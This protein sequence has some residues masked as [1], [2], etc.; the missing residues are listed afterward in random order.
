MSGRLK[1]VFDDTKEANRQAIVDALSGRTLPSMLDI[2]PH[3]GGFTERVAKAVGA[4]SIDGIELIP[5]HVPAAE[6]RGIKVTLGDVDDGLPY[7]DESFD[8]VL[9]NQVIEH[10]RSTDQFMTEIRRV[11]RPNGIACVSTN[12][13]SSWH[14]IISLA[15][16]HQPMPMHVSDEVIIGNPMN[17]E[18]GSEHEDRGRTHLRLFTTRALVELAEHH[19][20]K[21][22]RVEHVGYYPLSPR[23]APR[24]VK[25]DGR[26]AAYMICLLERP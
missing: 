23:L 17:P 20:L 21:A 1:R 13:L 10:V 4:T 3:K 5:D 2:G 18:Q 12:N 16:G 15:L 8:L 25:I 24:A 22:T 14:N 7:P 9:A 6:A 11:L 26:H 19:G